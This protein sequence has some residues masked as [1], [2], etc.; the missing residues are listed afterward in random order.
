MGH[1]L[2]YL[3]AFLLLTLAI[4]AC[5]GGPAPEGTPPPATQLRDQTIEL[6]RGLS[7][8]DFQVTHPNVPTDMGGG[9]TLS[10]V[11]GSA[12]F[13][14]KAKMAAD[15]AF[16]RVA[17][18][19]GIVQIGDATFL[20]GPIGDKWQEV[21]PSSLPFNFRGMNNS[22]ADA[23]RNAQNLEAAAGEKIDG[24]A[25]FTLRGAIMSDDLRGLV[26][27]AAAGLSLTLT[28]W[29]R[30]SDGLPVRVVLNG[31][32]I[33]TDQADMVRQL[34]LTQF[35]APVSVEPPI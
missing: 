3:V 28:A 5:R 7:S 29:V 34:E 4:G 22:V 27:A 35:N 21:D 32:V 26:P 6:L 19:F 14:D 1:R 30:Q 18:K 23:L 25:T 10:A 20:Q 24:K 13:P 12:S 31:P 33:D 16:Q 17:I 9:I 2:D 11:T 15:G 8:V